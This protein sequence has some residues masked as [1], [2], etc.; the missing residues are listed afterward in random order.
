MGSQ[1][2]LRNIIRDCNDAIAARKINAVKE[3]RESK[4]WE[5]ALKDELQ[6]LA[7]EHQ[8]KMKQRKREIE[9]QYRLEDY[10]RE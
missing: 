7:L 2:L 3:Y 10:H 5:E 4:E 9:Q 1:K 8:K 6:M